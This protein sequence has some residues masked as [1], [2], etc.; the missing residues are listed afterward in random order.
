M[1][2]HFFALAISGLLFTAC[3]NAAPKDDHGHEHA[4]GEAAHAEGSHTHAD[5]TSHEG[6]D[7]TDSTKQE[8][9]KVIQDSTLKD[10]ADKSLESKKEH[11][12]EDGETHA[13]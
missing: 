12:H 8:E 5:G 1:K 11:K 10:D 13:H 2:K 7:H 9:F 3:N 6:P 4:E